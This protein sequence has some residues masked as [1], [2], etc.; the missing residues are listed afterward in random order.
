[1]Y[2]NLLKSYKHQL[3][4]DENWFSFQIRFSWKTLKIYEPTDNEAQ[5]TGIRENPTDKT[6]ANIGFSASIFHRKSGVRGTQII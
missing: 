1:M 6:T 2:K 3:F 4:L 5:G